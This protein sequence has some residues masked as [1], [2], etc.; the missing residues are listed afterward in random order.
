M[1]GIKL[2]LIALLML[3]FAPCIGQSA[4]ELIGRWTADYEMDDEKFSVVYEFKYS[5]SR[6]VAYARIIRSSGGETV[7]MNDLVMNDIKFLEGKGTANYMIDYEG[8]RYE[9]EAE[10]E[11]TGTGKLKVSYSYYGFGDDETWVRAQ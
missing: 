2:T 1:N 7:P 8:E 11:M 4:D 9:V 10:L 6:L 3:V 5:S